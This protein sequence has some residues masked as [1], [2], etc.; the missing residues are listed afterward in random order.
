MFKGYPTT[1][2]SGNNVR[3]YLLESDFLVYFSSILVYLKVVVG[4]LQSY[5]ICG[6]FPESKGV[7]HYNYS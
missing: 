6:K 1:S 2:I 3:K 5:Y 4:Y 7:S